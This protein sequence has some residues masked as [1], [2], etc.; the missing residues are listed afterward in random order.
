MLSR[1]RPTAYILA[2]TFISL[3]ELTTVY[4]QQV[5]RLPPMKGWLRSIHIFTNSQ[6]AA[7]FTCRSHGGNSSIIDIQDT[8][9]FEYECLNENGNPFG[10]NGTV[11]WSEQCQ[12]GYAA[13]TSIDPVFG[14]V[15]IS[16][17]TR[18]FGLTPLKPERNCCKVGNPIVVSSRRKQQ[19][20]THYLG[21]G[22]FPLRFEHTYISSPP[23]FQNEISNLSNNFA[24]WRHNYQKSLSGDLTGSGQNALASAVYT[25]E[26]EFWTPQAISS[27][28]SVGDFIYASRP[29][30][31]SITFRGF[32]SSPDL[33]FQLQNTT[34]PLGTPGYRLRT[35]NDFDEYYD[36]DGR[37]VAVGN[38]NGSVQR[39]QYSESGQLTDVTD[40]YGRELTFAY[41]SQGYLN[42]MTDPNGEQTLFEYTSNG[43]LLSITYPNTG[44]GVA[45]KLYHYESTNDTR[46]LTGVT[47]ERTVRVSTW[48]YDADRFAELS[49][50]PGAINRTMLEKPSAFLDNIA[51]TNALGLTEIYRFSTVNGAR[52]LVKVNRTSTGGIPASDV[53]YT[54]DSNGLITSEIDHEG[55]IT[56]YVR[57]GRDLVLTETLAAASGAERTITRSWHPDYRIPTQEIF[58]D[59]TIDYTHDARGNVLNRTVTDNATSESRVWSYTY[60]TFGKMLTEDG[61]RTDVNDITTY[62]YHNCTTGG[63]CGQL[64]TV[65]DAVGNVTTIPDYNAHG[66]PTRIID[67]NGVV[68]T[69]TYNARQWLTSRTTDGQTV[70][71]DYDATGNI[72]RVTL[73]DNTFTAYTWDEANRLVAVNDAESNRIDW[74]LDNAG[75]RTAEVFKG[76]DGSVTKTQNRVYDALNRMIGLVPAHGG[77]STYAY[78][79]NSNQ[80]GMIDA[81]SR[82][83]G[84]SFDALDR[85]ASL[86]DAIN[87]I[88][89]Y[90]YDTQDNIVSVTDPENL[91]T[92]YTYNGFSDQLSV[93]SPD[94]GTTTYTV[95]AAG[96]RLSETDAR[97][98]TV[99]YSYDA[100]NRLTAVTYPDNS[101]NITY[102]Y[103]QGTNGRGRLTGMTD[104]SGSMS[105]GYDARGNLI[106]VTQTIDG[107]N[108][109]QTYS[110]NGA[111]RPTG[112]T[113]PSG[114]SITYD[115]DPSGRIQDVTS[116]A[117]EPLAT[118]IDRLPFG[119][120]LTMTLGNGIAR[121]RTYDLDYR[122]QGMDDAGVL[123]RNY[124]IDAVDNITAI[125]DGISPAVSQLFTY[126]ALDRLDFATGNYGDKSYTY[127]GIGNR[128]SLT[129]EQGGSTSTD[130]YNYASGSHPSGCNNR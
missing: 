73:P 122:I 77:Q 108:Y 123:S 49:S 89:T 93:T 67:P 10:V 1:F 36:L 130:N 84:Q 25:N 95:D 126:D 52:R 62:T 23:G 16:D 47:D 124:A 85:L 45:K 118:Q 40:D 81:A 82:S 34:T 101:L 21:A 113:L 39:L 37:L 87:G 9:E 41:N 63:E 94:T 43:D 44:D 99:D 104:E 46:L 65:T 106:S 75:N 98:V 86:Q 51:V 88:T 80:T 68:T 103:D 61:P 109:T 114:R 79:N 12:T 13:S 35:D 8:H 115:Y 7:N 11:Q 17:C 32:T 14:R 117:S 59:Y 72:T 83:T 60:D 129:T 76:P 2:V 29:D 125:T 119:P 38:A 24:H 102:A 120:S 15:R 3:S 57:D 5:E 28:G 74:T 6:D 30:G 127:D 58:P 91:T 96:N 50:G 78:D 110:Y 121:T 48:A 92:T 70:R 107:H 53:T 33:P 105:Y 18:S 56:R 22:D 112:M 128:L 31:S 19:V 66:Q 111:D 69:L 90:T 4:A 100:L 116:N 55:N 71:I 54:Y 26:G 20:E 27:G 97:G 42:S 64:H